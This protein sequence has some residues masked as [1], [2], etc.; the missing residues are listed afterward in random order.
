MT[1]L[2]SRAKKQFVIVKELTSSNITTGAE[3]DITSPATGEITVDDVILKTDSTGLADSG[4]SAQFEV[5]TDNDYGQ[6][7]VV[8]ENV[9]SNLG[10]NVTLDI[11]S[12]TTGQKT[13]LESGKK[14]YATASGENC[15]GSGNIK[16]YVYCST[17]DQNAEIY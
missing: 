13:V 11:S 15:T 14:L 10:A 8:Q 12:T 2:V 9:S 3:L 4:S 17:A 16:V 5:S 7:L 6:T 1:Q